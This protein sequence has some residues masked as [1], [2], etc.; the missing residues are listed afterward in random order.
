MG[1]SVDEVVRKGKAVA[2]G[3]R[4][5]LVY[6]IRVPRQ[7][8]C[9][10]GGVRRDVENLRLAGVRHVDF[11]SFEFGWQDDDDGSEH[12]VGLEGTTFRLVHIPSRVVARLT[13][14]AGGN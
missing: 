14:D 3:N 12:P 7:D 6:D 4:L 5:D 11:T 13:L 2:R 10:E 8:G 1:R 9:A